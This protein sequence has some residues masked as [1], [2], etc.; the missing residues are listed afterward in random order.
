MAKY[1][2]GVCCSNN[3]VPVASTGAADRDAVDAQCRLADTDG[4]ALTVLSAGA[5]TVVERK[6]VADHGDAMQVS[7]AVADQHGALDRCADFAVFDPVSFGALK[8]VFARSD[9]DLAAAEIRRV[10]AVLDR[11]YNFAG[12]AVAGEH[13]GVGHARHGY[14]REAFATAV[15]GRLHAHQPGVLP[16]L[17]ITDEYAV[18]DQHGAICRRAFVVDRQRAAAQRHGPVVD[19]GDAFGRHLLPHEA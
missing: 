12:L 2:H 19:D 16:V 1:T 11:G 13:V 10:D 18:L 15:A 3:S 14:V 9:V 4:H 5:D 6:V 17:H 7:R 8:D